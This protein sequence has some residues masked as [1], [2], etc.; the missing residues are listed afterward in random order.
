[1][2]DHE[3]TPSARA[4]PAVDGLPAGVQPLEHLRG[5]LAGLD[6]SGSEGLLVMTHKSPDPDAL[7]A[8]AGL[9]YLLEHAFGLPH[10]IAT[11]GRIFRAEN[12]AMVR[13]LGLSF[14]DYETIDPSRFGGGMLVDTQPS[15]GHTFHPEGLPIVA[16]FDHHQPPA[17]ATAAPV[18][19]NDVRLGIG[20]T[21]SMM[22]EYIRDAGIE[23][24][25]SVATAICCGVRFDTA[26]LS[27]HATP[28]D[29]EAFYETFRRGDRRMLARI[30]RPSLPTTYYRELH[31]SLSRARR[32][33]PLVYGLLGRVTNPESVAE[34]AD[35]FLRMDGCRW[36]FVGGA[37]DGVYHLSLRTR[38]RLGGAYRLLEQILDGEGSFGGR[39]SVA[40]GQIPLE[41]AD[42]PTLRNLERRLRARA[43]RLVDPSELQGDDKR[44]GIRLTRLP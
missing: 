42:D 18:P 29:S 30:S 43:L 40:G 1:M 35:F 33:G 26:D 4:E 38:V 37:Y 23:M 5:V 17:G 16:V 13:E 12:K 24:N 11:T 27:V 31:F 19:H 39:G 15:F 6:L 14:D 22:Y 21:S 9:G 2:R 10:T 44:T 34:M 41:S 20:A 36:S 3:T 7:G 25:E 8:L 28:L 32:Y